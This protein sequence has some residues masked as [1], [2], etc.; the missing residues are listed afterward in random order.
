MA[1][2]AESTTVSVERSVAEIQRTLQRYGA[3]QFGYGQDTDRGLASIQ[4][5]AHERQVRFVLHLPGR[6]E[7]RFTH[8]RR[9]QSS[10][11]TPRSPEAAH[12]AWEQ[13]CRQRWRALSLA[14]KAKLEAVEAGISVFEDEF[15]AHIVLP[16]GTTVSEMLRPQIAH[17]YKTGAPIPGIAGL[18]PAPDDDAR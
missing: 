7:K 8:T 15:L 4:F 14:I 6:T 13:A 1:K 10:A 17:A 11:L 9:N 2:Y 3:A 12:K 5:R 18:L 16:G